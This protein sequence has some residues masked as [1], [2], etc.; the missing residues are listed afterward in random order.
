MQHLYSDT[1]IQ[2]GVETHIGTLKK[3]PPLGSRPKYHPYILLIDDD[4]DDLELLSS[5]LEN[6]GIHTQ[7]F[8]S[9]EAAECLLHSIVHPYL[10]PSLIIVDYNM[11]RSNGEQVLIS[12]KKSFETQDIPVVVYSTSM[13]VSLKLVLVNLGAYDCF[14][15]CSSFNDLRRQAQLFKKIAYSFN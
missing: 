2:A 8:D 12:L 5:A 9:V 11:P 10:M 14:T 4:H 13:P 3:L 7:S 15:K 1:I 6:L